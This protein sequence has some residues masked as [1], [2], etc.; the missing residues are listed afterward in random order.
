MLAAQGPYPIEFPRSTWSVFGL[1]LGF[2]AF[3]AAGIALLLV[4]DG[5]PSFPPALPRF[6]LS[7]DSLRDTIAWA[8]LVFFGGGGL[9]VAIRL[10]TTPRI[11][12]RV[13]ETGFSLGAFLSEEFR[14][15]NV[16]AVELKRRLFRSDVRVVFTDDYV[17]NNMP[18]LTKWGLGIK[19]FDLPLT[20]SGVPARCLFETLRD[21]HSAYRSKSYVTD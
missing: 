13:T 7:D 4:P 18:G 14:W 12:A 5:V 9:F 10:A 1:L 11:A 16:E 17:T 3:V 21:A 2:V 19:N 8:C 20:L 15:S 6:G